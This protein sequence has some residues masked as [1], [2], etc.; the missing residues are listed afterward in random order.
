MRISRHVL[1]SMFDYANVDKDELYKSLRA[2]GKTYLKPEFRSAWSY[3]NPTYCYC[4][5]ICEMVYF[6]K[7]P[8]GTIPFKLKV[9]KDPGLHRFLQW[10]DK[11]IIDLSAEQ[12]DNYEDV[13]YNNAKK[14]MFLQSG[15]VGPSKRAQILAVTMGYSNKIIDNSRRILMYGSSEEISRFSKRME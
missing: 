10:P 4:Y 6:Y 2:M 14:C 3:D 8:T 12:F 15:C 7:A 5:V 11:T 13:V 1:Q 9:P